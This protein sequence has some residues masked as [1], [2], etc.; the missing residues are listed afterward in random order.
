MFFKCNFSLMMHKFHV[1]F[2]IAYHNIELNIASGPVATRWLQTICGI[3]I[4]CV[5]EQLAILRE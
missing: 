4:L 1:I 5:E 3:N 2:T